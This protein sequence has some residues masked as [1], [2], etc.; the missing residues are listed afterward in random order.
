MKNRL[1]NL[2][3]VVSSL[4]V[5]LTAPVR[6]QTTYEYKGNPFTNFSCGQVVECSTP[7]PANPYTS[8]RATDFVSAILTFDNPLPA[9]MPLQ[10]VSTRAGFQLTM[11]DG[12]QTLTAPHRLAYA[13]VSRNRR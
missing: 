4:V 11:H 10:D 3:L 9:N 7:S 5:F 1:R 2:V 13:Y 12:Q 6:G 8:Y